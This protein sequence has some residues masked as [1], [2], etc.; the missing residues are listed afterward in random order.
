MIRAALLAIAC[1]ALAAQQPTDVFA[2]VRFLAGAWDAE[3]GGQP[4]R[5][6]GEASFRF[7]LDGKAMVR[8]SVTRFPAQEGRPAFTH[9]DL[10]TIY[11]EGGKLKALY[12]DT[13]GHVIHYAVEALT[14]GQGVRFQSEPQPGPVFRLTYVVKGPD[15]LH[16]AFAVAGPGDPAAFTT[17]VEGDCRRKR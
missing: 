8:R 11:P 1:V 6:T 9:E 5:N 7:E 4:G 17:H 2:P 16:V 3:G 10:L 13:E 12:L 15:I 14:G